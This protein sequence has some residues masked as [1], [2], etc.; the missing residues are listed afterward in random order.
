MN[1]TTLARLKRQ[2]GSFVATNNLNPKTK[3]GAKAI[4]AFW[5]GALCG[6]DDQTNAYVTICLLSGRHEDLCDY[7]KEST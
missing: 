2:C 1:S 7:T 6:L 5:Y 3:T 4:H